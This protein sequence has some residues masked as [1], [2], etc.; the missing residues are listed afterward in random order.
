M[1]GRSS[2]PTIGMNIVV[3]SFGPSYRARANR[4]PEQERKH[5]AHQREAHCC[6]PPPLEHQERHADQRH[7]HVVGTEGW[8]QHTEEA[9]CCSQPELR[10]V[11][12]GVPRHIRADDRR[13][14]PSRMFCWA[15]RRWRRECGHGY[16]SS[17]APHLRAAPLPVS[18]PAQRPEPHDPFR[19][20]GLSRRSSP[21]L[22]GTRLG[23]S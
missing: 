19:G 16:R 22:P 1:T 12:Q 5:N 11:P 18:L 7:E 17:G 20:K 6:E 8:T 15:W 13:E 14:E 10:A 9:V 21:R 23:L 3:V 2:R 4:F